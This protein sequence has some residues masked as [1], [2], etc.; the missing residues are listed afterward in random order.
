MQSYIKIWLKP[1]Q[2]D[3]VF[4][5]WNFCCFEELKIDELLLHCLV[6]LLLV[7]S[8]MSNLYHMVAIWL[9]LMIIET[10]QSSHK[11][12]S[13]LIL[14]GTISL[15]QIGAISMKMRGDVMLMMLGPDATCVR[16]KERKPSNATEHKSQILL[17]NVLHHAFSSPL[18][19]KTYQ[20]WS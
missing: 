1:L 7:I 4:G 2:R 16:C 5:G 8:P 17:F 15:L 13:S 18:W 9:S 20:K 6:W 3:N 11:L 19:K 10:K 14:C 12:W